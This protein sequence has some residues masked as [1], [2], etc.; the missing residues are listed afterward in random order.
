LVPRESRAF[1]LALVLF[2]G[3][4]FVGRQ[5]AQN[6][7]SM[8]LVTSQTPSSTEVAPS[9]TATATSTPTP[10]HT[11][12]PPP[13][14]TIQTSGTVLLDETNT[15][16]YTLPEDCL[17]H[18]LRL[19]V[20]GNDIYALD[21]G[22]LQLITLGAE[23]SCRQVEP[24]DSVAVQ[25]VAD[26]SLGGNGD[27]LLLLDQAGNVFRYLPASDDWMMERAADAPEASSRQYLA[28]VCGYGDSFY[29]LDTNVGQIWRH[30]EE[31]AAVVPADSD[32]RE[33]VDLA[34]GEAS[35][36]L[37]REG[38]GGP[39]RLHRLVGEPL[40]SDPGFVPPSDMES[41]S[42]LFLG[43]R[44]DAFVYVVD[45]DHGRLRLLDAA[46]G[47]LVREY[48]FAEERLEID[49][50]FSQGEKLYVAAKGGIYVYP[51][52]P[53]QPVE[54]EAAPATDCDLQTLPPN[55]PL[56][57][58]LLPSLAMPLEGAT[59]PDLSFRLPGAP[60]SYRYG[61]HE[62]IDFYSA[63]GRPVTITTPVLSVAEGEVIRADT[64]YHPPELDEMEAMLAQAFEVA[65]TPE[66]VLDAL[67]GR[68]V[69]IDHGGGLASRYCHLS[70]VAQ[71]L[72]VGDHVAQGQTL[73]YV[74]NSGTPSSY[75]DPGSEIHLH[76]EIRIGQGY[77]GQHLRPIEVKRWLRQVFD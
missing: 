21:S 74:G 13:T 45:R 18:P 55:D 51:R 54:W 48:V 61:V 73:G 1:G 34:V 68:Q 2:V 50:V 75:Y 33:S 28:S 26:I 10:T 71:D 59:I 23:P 17:I 77:L 65:Y 76:L 46:T 64:D 11:P 25:E 29:L 37:A 63:A 38:Y 36:V 39:L 53:G 67:R 20:K 31:Q 72:Q 56:V 42:L 32:L 22:R 40:R 24:S 15:T 52:E 62:G 3:S 6:P 69:W 12:T 60:R 7:V 47:D 44:P 49:A 19:A 66:E 58:E 35:Y 9:P 8:S 5:I 41:P 43:Q 16:L 27:S 30:T 70:A 4:L 14:P 57:L